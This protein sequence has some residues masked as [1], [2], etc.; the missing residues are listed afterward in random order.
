MPFDVSNV[1]QQTL[2]AH[3]MFNQGQRALVAVSGGADSMALLHLL[4]RAERAGAVAHFDHQTRDGASA[5]DAAFVVDAA[6]SLGLPCYTVSQ[7]IEAMATERRESFEMVARE[8]RYAFFRETA[9]AHGFDVIATGH[10]ADDQAETVLLRLI[11]GVSPAGLAGIPPVRDL[12]GIRVVRPLLDCTRAALVAWLEAEGIAWREDTSNDDARFE[13]NKVRRDLLPHLAREY[14]PAVGVALNRL[15]R[16]QR[17]DDALLGQYTEEALARCLDLGRRLQRDPFL[18][19]D[20]ALRYRCM[21]RCIQIAGGRSDYDIVARAVEAA[22]SGDAGTQV[23]LGN[24]V[25]MY[26]AGHHA[27]F[28]DLAP[29]AL[30]EDL[31]LPIPGEASGFGQIFRARRLDQLPDG[32]LAHY[33]HARR[34][35][36]DGDALGETFTVR[37]RRL[38]DRFQ[39]MGMAGTK[40]LKD[41]FN[42]LGLTRPERDAQIV[43]ESG[44]AIVWIAG[45]TVSGGAALKADSGHAVELT[46]TEA[47]APDP[48]RGAKALSVGGPVLD[49]QVSLCIYTED[50][51]IDALTA[52]LGIAPTTA[53]RRGD[54]IGKRRPVPIGRWE[55]EPPDG[56]GFE[57][58]LAYLADNT[59]SD[60]AV[61]DAIKQGHSIQLQCAVFLSGWTEGFELSEEWIAEAARRHWN[62]G[63]SMYSADGNEILNSFLRNAPSGDDN[64]AEEKE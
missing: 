18:A 7:P 20:P 46:V 3:R 34:Q 32:P 22:V 60:P 41:V 53:L 23:D 4:H 2:V 17:M 51:D 14:N 12:D 38:G 37:R 49:S 13:R 42:D 56:L 29:S 62:L 27:V 48:F 1:M 31:I 30:E 24:G 6:A 40:K 54:V 19:L 5:D 45:Y 21:V 26:L 25:A 47:D 36:F 52:M 15:A 10:H 43:I 55:L 59:P 61:W 58:K 28:A 35:V 11:R 57:K 9:I 16:L 33:C 50:I 63:L 44:G 64:L 39:P 8:A